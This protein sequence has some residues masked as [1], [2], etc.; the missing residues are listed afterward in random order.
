[1]SERAFTDLSEFIAIPRVEAVAL[2]PD[3]TRAVL[4]VATLSEDA[5]SYERA[6]WET[7]ADGSGAPRR[8]TRSVKGEGG[9]QFTAAGDVLFV[10]ARDD[11]EV[12]DE[13]SAQLWLLPAG[14]GEARPVTRLA[15]GAGGVAAVA[16][17]GSRV[18][19][20]ASLMPSATTLEDDARIRADR[21]KR[22][23]DA[24]LH[25]TYPVRHWDHDLGPAEPHLFALDLADLDESIPARKDAA[26]KDTPADASSP[27]PAHLPRPTDLTPGRGRAGDHSGVAATPDGATVVAALEVPEGRSQ[28]TRLVSIDVATGAHTVLRDEPRVD[29]GTPRVSP[30]GDVLVYVRTPKS[31]S[32]GPRDA[33]LWACA[34]DG[35][36]PRRLAQGWD[37]WVSELAFAPAGDALVATADHDGRCPLF[38]IPLDG[39]A[40]TRLTED[41]FGYASINVDR[42]TGEVVALRSTYAQAPHPVRV[43]LDGTVTELASPAPAP[44]VPGTLTEVEA[45]AADG[46]RVRAWLVLPEGADAS[47]P[48]PLLLWIHGGPMNSWNGWSWRWCAQLAAARGYA[49]LLPDPALSTGYGL[50]FIGRGWNSWG[51]RPFTDLMAIT[52]AAVARE[53]VDGSRTAAMGGSF[54]GYMANWIAGHT[55]RFDA[56]VTHASLW[57]MD[58]FGPTTD[59]ADYWQE[60]FTPEGALENSPHR[61]VDRITTPMLVIH[62]DKDY[63]VPIGEGLRLWAELN[64]HSADEDGA[65]PHRFLYFPN[66]NHWVLAPQHAIVWYETVFAFLG[67]HVLHHVPEHPAVLG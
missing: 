58:Q 62:G 16:R 65:T 20:E 29:F 36:A 24:I 11:A 38:L 7:P 31:T 6:L 67:E 32:D 64:E 47:S 22:K 19:I 53:D 33:E 9:A 45:T 61:F 10:S 30:D 17:E 25:S 12:K 55:D 46:T 66:E 59:H 60:I 15:G 26:A 3:G 44:E 50:D 52:D 40:P 37:R 4:T 42:A 1:M 23:V 27:Y 14:G 48:A 39:G 2:S 5:T 8:L 54:G 21:K 49:V 13:A 41:D 63:R 43:A 51:D 18:V 35:S 56:I 57:A 28:R 34:L